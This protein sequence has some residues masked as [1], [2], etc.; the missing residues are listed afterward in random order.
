MHFE[1]SGV[2]QKVLVQKKRYIH[3]LFDAK[4]SKTKQTKNSKS[5]KIKIPLK[6]NNLICWQK[7]I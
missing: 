6:R 1:V 2:H 5:L 7:Q 3:E 4:C